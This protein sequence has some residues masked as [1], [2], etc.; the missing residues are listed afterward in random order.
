MRTLK[1]GIFNVQI[2][3]R[4]YKSLLARFDPKEYRKTSNLPESESHHTNKGCIFCLDMRYGVEQSKCNECKLQ[5]G[6]LQLLQDFLGEDYIHIS[7]GSRTMSYDGK[8]GLKAITKI[9]KALKK[10]PK[11]K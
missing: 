8:K 10:L 6:C 7:P 11:E 9:Y 5:S 4:E 1:H 3:E 2:T